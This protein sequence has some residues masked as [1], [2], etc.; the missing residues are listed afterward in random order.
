MQYETMEITTEMKQETQLWAF[1]SM[2]FPE[3]V[4][5]PETM[6][7]HQSS[8]SRESPVVA[9][10]TSSKNQFSIAESPIGQKPINGKSIHS[11][12]KS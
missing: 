3:R 5:A 2:H 6:G 11:M 1:F 10:E 9:W 12:T 4:T 7:P 8:P